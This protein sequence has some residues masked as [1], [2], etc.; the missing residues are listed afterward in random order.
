M[1]AVAVELNPMPRTLSPSFEG[2]SVTAGGNLRCGIGLRLP[3][4]EE[5]IAHPPKV[6]WMEVHTENYFGDGGP[7]LRSIAKV[8]EHFPLSLHGVG[9]SL[10]SIDAPDHAHI[11][12]V[13]RLVRQL[14]P[15]FV[16]EHVSWTSIDGRFTPDLLPM[17]YTQEAL[18]HLARRIDEVQ[19]RLGRQLLVENISSY[20][21]FKCSD[22]SEWQFLTELVR[23]CRCG[24]LLDVNN[25]YVSALNHGFDPYEYLRGVPPE[26]V[27]E[28]HLAGHSIRRIGER[29]VRVD[30]HDT[31]V[32]LDVWKLY[33]FAV[34]RFG[35]LP[36]L[37][38]WDANLPTLQVL[39][40]EA[41]KA[42]HIMEKRH[43]I[44]A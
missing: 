3:H 8:R 10:G 35:A 1:N 39:V 33:E 14:E 15:K 4:Q 27:Q 22:M 6:G 21:R 40:D 41:M 19:D 11:E 16:S 7:H 17:P 25:V 37:I 18:R 44:A 23:E 31:H 24:L 29:E 20:V 42:E 13:A 12:K 30:T 28:M 26:A 9:L 43:D 32:C 38:E 5:V 34:A 36:T 2:D